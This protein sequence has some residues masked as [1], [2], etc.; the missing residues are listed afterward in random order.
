MQQ[1]GQQTLGQ[2]HVQKKLSG[3]KQQTEGMTSNVTGPTWLTKTN[4]QGNDWPRP[5]P[6]MFLLAG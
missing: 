5:C 4:W 6:H 1:T 2:A 3:Q